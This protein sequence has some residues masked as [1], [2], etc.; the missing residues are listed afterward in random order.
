MEK[1]QDALQKLRIA[2]GRF[3]LGRN[4][5]DQLNYALLW[6]YLFVCVVRAIVVAVTRSLIAGRV[7]DVL[8]DV[9][10]VAILFRVLSRNLPRRQA[11]NMRFLDWWRRTR[12]ITDGAIKR[13]KDKAHKYYTCKQCGTLCRVPAGKGNIIITCPKCGAKIQAKT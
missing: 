2:I 7:F 8:L 4:G 13:H 10:I 11:E 1:I 6:G 5:M 3:M 9:V 12:L